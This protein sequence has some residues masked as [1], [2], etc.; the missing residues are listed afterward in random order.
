M[1]SQDLTVAYSP[2]DA[3]LIRYAA[4][5]K[6][7]K[8]L[9]A[10]CN[11]PAEQALLRV[12]EILESRDVWTERERF[13]LYL[14]DIYDLKDTLKQKVEYSQDSKDT[15]NLISLLSQLGKALTNVSKANREISGV[16]TEVQA[17]FMLE[18]VVRAFDY[19]KKELASQY[20]DLPWEVIDSAFREGLA[21]VVTDDD[22]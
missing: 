9:A 21:S 1:T 14:Q 13:L 15:A 20:D 5:G 17:K 2:L 10:L 7:A 6:S 3:E 12:K 4:G 22:R 16:V 8:E 18:L 19:A 11:I